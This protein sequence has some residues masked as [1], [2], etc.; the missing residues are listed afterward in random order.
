[1]RRLRHLAL[2][3]EVQTAWNPPPEAVQGRAARMLKKGLRTVAS[4]EG[5]GSGV[6]EGYAYVGLAYRIG[7]PARAQLVLEELA[8]LS[9]IEGIKVAAKVRREQL[10]LAGL[11]VDGIAAD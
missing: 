11:N 2:T 1:M 6:L 8:Q 10:E 4:W 9:T 5:E 3:G 7:G